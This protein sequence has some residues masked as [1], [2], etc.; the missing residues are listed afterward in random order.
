M[1]KSESDIRL[2]KIT[3]EQLREKEDIYGQFIIDIKLDVMRWILN[4]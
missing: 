2:M 1:I 4:D 3:L